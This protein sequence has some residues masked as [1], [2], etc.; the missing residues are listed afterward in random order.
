[1]SKEKVVLPTEREISTLNDPLCLT[2]YSPP[3]MGKTTLLSHLPNCLILDFE[4]GSKYVDGM[5]IEVESLDH[6]QRI[7]TEIMKKGR[8]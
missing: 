2:V 4:L 6:L 3:K 1:M 5:K 8:P 7:G